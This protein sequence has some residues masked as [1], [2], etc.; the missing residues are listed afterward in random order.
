VFQARHRRMT[1]A[2]NVLFGVID[3]DERPHLAVCQR[4]QSVEKPHLRRASKVPFRERRAAPE[5][6]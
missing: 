2:A 6:G 5:P 1:L 3:E 4:P